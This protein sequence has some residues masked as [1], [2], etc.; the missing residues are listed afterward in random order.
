MES[1]S[2]FNSAIRKF[3][4]YNSAD[5]N[6]KELIYAQRMSERL[7][8]FKPNSPEYLK[9]AVHCQHIGRWKISRN[10]YPDGKKGYI[11]WRNKLKAFHAE[12]AGAILVECGYDHDTIDRVEDLLE[13]KDLRSNP[14]TQLLEDVACMVFIE[15]YLEE[16][17]ARHEDEKVID[18]LAKTLKKMSPAAIDVSGTFKLDRKM[19]ELLTRAT[20]TGR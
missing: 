13:K 19:K 20:G 7:E 18:I 4:E 11:A 2:L 5:P 17:A 10:T 6:G 8:Q 14:D 3:D 15:Y 1:T 12:T 9:L 16:F